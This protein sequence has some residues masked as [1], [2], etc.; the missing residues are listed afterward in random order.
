MSQGRF[1][2][3]VGCVVVSG[4][5][6]M[7]AAGVA[8]AEVRGAEPAPV[9]NAG[10]PRA[11]RDTGRPLTLAD[12]IAG[13]LAKNDDIRVERV[14]LDS[15]SASIIGAKGAYDPQL[16][17]N[18]G[19]ESAALPV[20]SAFSGA[21]AGRLA[22]T[23][24]SAQAGASLD[25]LLPTG[26]VLSLTADS[27]R[28][29]TN[30]AFAL[31]SPAYQTQLGIAV[32]QPLLRDR[33]IDAARLALRVAATDRAMVAGTLRQ[34]VTDTVAAVERAY[35][36]LVAARRAV[37]VQEEAVGLASQQL[38]ETQSRI[39]SGLSPEN[40]IAQ[41]RAEL[42]RRRGDLLAGREAASRAETALKALI[43]GDDAAAWSERLDP[44]DE[45]AVAVKP[46]DVAAAMERALDSRPELA[47]AAATLD[48]RRIEAA[49]AHDRVRPALDLV[50]SYDRYG[51]AGS[52]NP[53]STAIPGLSSGVPAGLEGGL[54]DAFSQLGHGTFNDGRI[55]LEL[56]VPIGN[57][58]AR[59]NAAIA[60]DAE[61]AAEAA[62]SKERKAVRAEVLDAVAAT[63]TAGARIEAARAAREAAE[64]QLAAEEDRF[65]VGLSTN[66][67]VLTR[68]NDLAAARLA[69]INAQTDYRTALTDLA[70]AS[71][72]LL[73]SRRI[74]LE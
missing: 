60:K 72:S 58:A 61:L 16:A 37:G 42:E 10:A 47:V 24:R 25:Q 11:E 14:A 63:E 1:Q 46:V 50:A 12:A 20:N 69:E 34:V 26:A 5:A 27:S 31:L 44:V 68:Q 17:L 67:L 22:P 73:E 23:N 4:L 15:A 30:G 6:A 29:K 56:T 57:R 36:G 19:F 70:R 21:P 3:G 41:P 18:A 55:A 49:F 48:R 28:A 8:S 43:L 52:G 64:V 51:L 13:A 32:R 54:H 71:S 45:I 40:E 66:F 9:A 62:L 33:A 7:V 2:R 39:E 53:A 65:K 38:R 59:A 74:T 35:W